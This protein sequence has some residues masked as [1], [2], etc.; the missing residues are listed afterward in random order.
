MEIPVQI[1]FHHVAH[2]PALE[3]FIRDKATRLRAM[4][5]RLLRCHINL[6]RAHC[7]NLQGNPFQ[8]RLVLHVSGGELVVNRDH[9]K[10]VRVALHEAFDAARRQL[11]EHAQ[12]ARRQLKH[13]GSALSAGNQTGE[14]R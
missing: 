3:Q 5:P 10:D 1:V 12:R 8:A 4:Y 11:E 9:H 14:G 7:H 2:S 6:E 13:H